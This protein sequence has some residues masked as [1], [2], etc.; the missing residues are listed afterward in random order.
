MYSTQENNKRIAKNTMLLYLRMIFLM[1]VTLY[2]SRVILN[3]LGVSDFGIY[4]VV[5]GVVTTLGFISSSLSGATSRFITYEL[6]LKDKGNVTD[7][8]RCSV[9]IHYLLAIVLFII[10][11]TIGLWFLM[12]KLVIPE[13]RLTAAFWVYQCSVLTFIVLLISVPYNAL[14]IAHEKMNMYAYFSIFEAVARLVVAILLAYVSEDRLIVYATLLLAVQLLVRFLNMYY[15]NHFLPD[16]SSKWLWRTDISKKMIVYAGWTVNGNLAYSGYTQ[17]LNILLNLFYGPV[18]NAARGVAVQVQSAVYQF[19]GNFLMAV[20]PQI[21]KSYAQ[22]DLLYMHSLVLNSCR[23][24]FFLIIIVTLPLLVNTE[25]I[26]SLWL[27]LVPNYSVVFTQLMLLICINNAFAQPLL[28]AIHA[29]GN[30]KKFQMIE[31]AMLLTIVPIAYI[32]LKFTQI[33]PEGVFIVHFVIEIITQLARVWIVF[34]RIN[35]DK[36]RYF[37]D[38]F[39]P[40]IKVAIPVMLVGL[41]IKNY[42]PTINFSTFVIN[43]LFCFLSV[44]T[45][46]L[47]IGL[48]PSERLL[49]KAKIKTII[50]K[51][52]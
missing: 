52:V 17:G 42:C 37:I 18:V 32:L 16:V 50:K 40:A 48:K 31:G 29:T 43:V 10:A 7:V 5:G 46:L 36:K 41:L 34:P 26:L 1:C 51:K 33:P 22:G 49:L 21:T 3:A 38:V 13:D 20:R 8:F 28:M 24:S 9:S 6:G 11:E 39:I 15:C 14:I 25:Y 44:V 45:I 30:I 12:E 27:G 35:L 19:F 23:Y 47:Y 2:T 4:N